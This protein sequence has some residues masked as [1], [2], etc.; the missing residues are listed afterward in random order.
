MK[1]ASLS[2]LVL[3]F[4]TILVS[5]NSFAQHREGR[6]HGRHRP[7]PGS[8]YDQNSYGTGREI[9][10]EQLN[11]NIRSYERLRL[12]DLLRLS[13]QEE[14]N[15][16]ILSLSLTAQS[17]SYSS[18]QIEVSQFGRL[19]SSQI[20]SRQLSTINFY[21][22]ARTTI[23]G[24]EI[25]STSE[26]FLSSV[27]AEVIINRGHGPQGSGQ[28]P[29]NSIQTLRLN[30]SVMGY[31]SFSLVDLVRQQLRLNLRG[32]EI[33]GVTVYGQTSRYGRETSLQLE[34]NRRPVGVPQYLSRMGRQVELSVYSFEEVQDLNL[35]VNGE[36]QIFDV[37]IRVGHVRPERP[38][39][40]P[41]GPTG[42]SVQ[43]FQIRHEIS[44]VLPYEISRALG[45][46][47]RA[48][49]AIT[50]EARSRGQLQS[51]LS[52][53]T[54]YGESQGVLFIGPNQV[55]AT[56]RLRRPMFADELRLEASSSLLVE[57]IEVEFES[58]R[59]F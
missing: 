24:I 38:I 59:P 57:A 32:A 48:I 21:L 49:Q 1:K 26:I 9:L 54:K 46:E 52:L 33:Q 56:L 13:Y 2:F 3:F 5:L 27:V 34:L 20:V 47:R 41:T 22:P 16:E 25:S 39:P 11:Q 43:R 40:G 55:R 17:N 36:A 30:Q 37:I 42:P 10:R 19:I 14:R 50:I 6:N 8:A 15:I 51:Q 29:S 44:P 58:Y 7:Y 45:Y 18:A 23:D 4:S 53:L 31:G 35:V 28:V 12:S